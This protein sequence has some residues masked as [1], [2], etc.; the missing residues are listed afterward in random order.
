[1]ET[2]HPTFDSLPATISIVAHDVA[3]IKR[4]LA[5]LRKNFEPRTPS[6]YLTRQEVADWLKCDLSTV[7]NWT[8]KGKLKKH[9]IGDRV[10]YIRSEIESGMTII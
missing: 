4:L 3:E 10:Y 9:C 8:K 7:H 1:M 5:E 2:K 6:E